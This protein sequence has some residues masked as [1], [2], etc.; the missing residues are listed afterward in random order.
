MA[1]LIKSDWLWNVNQAEHNE[2]IGVLYWVVVGIG[3]SS[4]GADCYR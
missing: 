3:G 1:L 2:M 4:S